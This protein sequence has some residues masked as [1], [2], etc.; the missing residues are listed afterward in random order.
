MAAASLGS[1]LYIND[2]HGRAWT[3]V[4]AVSDGGGGE[5]WNDLIYVT[6]TQAWVV[7]GPA[8]TTGTTGDDIFVG[9]GGADTFV[10]AS[11]FGH[12][13]VKDFAAAGANHDT[14]QF[15]KSV[16]DSFASVLSHATQ[17]GQ[18]V[19][20]ATGGDTLTLKNTK[21]DALNSHDFHFA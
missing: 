9:K 1:F 21:I 11:N 5:V 8:D 3:R 10:F 4:A 18:D 20:I 2:T 17:S 16:F 14:L 12:D 15:S 7:Y 19:I 6:N 13:I